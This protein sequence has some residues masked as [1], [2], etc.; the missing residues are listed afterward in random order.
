M[1]F[2]QVTW[3]SKILALVLF[4]CLPFAGFWLGSR[5]EKATTVDDTKTE[6]TVSGY[7][8]LIDTGEIAVQTK[9][10]EGLL[11]YKGRIQVPDPC[12]YTLKETTVKT[13][14]QNTVE[15]RLNVG[16]VVSKPQKTCVQV[17][18]DK[19]FSGSLETSENSKVVVYFNGEKV[20]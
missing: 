15:I 19:Q 13:E 6:Q 7:T 3:Y 12:N 9:Y 14:N 17:L 4:I 1:K 20:E 16:K 5:Y 18:T 8:P 11:K 2:N 10:E